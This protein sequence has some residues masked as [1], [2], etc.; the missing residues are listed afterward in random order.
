MRYYRRCG[1]MDLTDRIAIETGL[2]KGESFSLDLKMDFVLIYKDQG[3]VLL[4]FGAFFL[5]ASRS[6]VSS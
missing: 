1:Q 3:F 4:D 5:K 2:C 6:S